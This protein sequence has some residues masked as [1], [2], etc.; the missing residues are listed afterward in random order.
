MHQD[1]IKALEEALDDEYKAQA[2]YSAVIDKF[3]PIRPFVNIVEAEERHAHALLKQFERLGVE[4]PPDAWAGQIKP[5]ET[6]EAACKAA[7]AAE[8]ENGEM[9]DRLL[10]VVRDETVR[11]VLRNLRDASQNRHLPAF[12]RCLRRHQGK[13]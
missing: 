2:T 9:Y 7:I 5:P 6:I 8:I 4:S 10:A 11:K 12:E 3:G 13:G 1:T